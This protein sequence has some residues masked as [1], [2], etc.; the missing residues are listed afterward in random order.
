[1]GGST[2]TVNTVAGATASNEEIQ[3]LSEN[4]YKFCIQLGPLL[5]LTAYWPPITDWSPGFWATVHIPYWRDPRVK[6][7]YKLP[8]DEFP[9]KNSEDATVAFSVTLRLYKLSE[10][11]LEAQRYVPMMSKSGPVALKD[12]R[13]QPVK[14]GRNEAC[15]CGSGVKFKHCHGKAKAR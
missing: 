14:V 7:S 3:R 11:A 12:G 8:R 10:Q 4:S 5:L 2:W 15:P 9:W 13:Y 1:M 6:V